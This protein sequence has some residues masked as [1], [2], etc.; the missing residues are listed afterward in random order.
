[1]S[2]IVASTT[3][4]FGGASLSNMIM[5]QTT[6]TK[7]ISLKLKC[8]SVGMGRGEM[9]WLMGL[10]GKRNGSGEIVDGP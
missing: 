2:I 3:I 6:L 9:R 4:N 5:D 7:E 1:M 10:D 8:W